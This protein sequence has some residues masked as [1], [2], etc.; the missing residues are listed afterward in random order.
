MG[1]PSST[2]DCTRR[3]TSVS[4]SIVVIP[5]PLTVS[6]IGIGVAVG[7]RSLGKRLR[8]EWQSER[9]V[10]PGR[11]AASEKLKNKVRNAREVLKRRASHRRDYTN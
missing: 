1:L 11:Q 6:A 10:T 3:S 9:R 7:V 2:R 8:L 4:N 5:S